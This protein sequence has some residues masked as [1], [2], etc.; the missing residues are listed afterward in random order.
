[1]FTLHNFCV[2]AGC[3]SLTD[4]P[5]RAWLIALTFAGYFLLGYG[6]IFIWGGNAHGV[7]PIWPATAFGLLM[8][9]RLSRGRA[10]DI[11]MLAAVLVAALLANEAGGAPPALAI[12][13]GVINLLDVSAA[14]L[15]VRTLGMPRMKTLASVAI[16]MLVAAASPALLGAGLSALLVAWHGG[17]DPLLTGMQWFFAN[18]LAVLILLPFGLTV[19]LRQFAKL[20]L[21][22]RVL[23]A[24][25]VF[26]TLAAVSVLGFRYSYPVLFLV[27]VMSLVA[28]V[29]FR[30]MGAGAALIVISMLAFTSVREMPVAHTLTWIETLQFYLAVCS[31][32]SVRTAMLLNE[33]DLH[34][35]I[36]ER[37]R[38]RAVRA[39]R[40]KS[41]LLAHVSH[42]ARSP[43]SA[44]IGFS[45]MLESGSL[46][47]DRAPEFAAIIAHNG[48]LLR[49]LHDDLLDLSRAEAGAL[50]IQSERVSVGTTL[51]SCV[52]AIRLDATLGG[53]DVLIEN[54]EDALAVTADP[55]RLAQIL[56]NLIANAFKYG[57]NFSPIRVRAHALDDGFGRIEI[58]NAGPGIPPDERGVVF[59][60][61][62]RSIEVGR[63]VP[64]AGLGL[65]IAK[66]LVE[67]QGGRIDFESVPGRQTRFWI[68]LPLAA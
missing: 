59:L 2:T 3:M 4:M 45:A 47:A 49:R 54:V 52:S 66:M 30:L 1:M 9:M 12:G 26:S 39:S 62:R 27:L 17:G 42:E 11:A 8:L 16:F 18:V 34:T 61:F 68:D 36:I 35:A 41:Q 19:S 44:I 38:Q 64:G 31:V 33:R 32:V 43:L 48:E 37:R 46:P 55:V 63:Q 7:T 65:S 20:R 25:V 28:S 56:N 67:A 10:D 15:A 50:S 24:L 22:H 23:E 29:R 51:R 57:D 60:P 21:E 14:I 5:R 6:G 40:F 13:Y 58:A 53:K